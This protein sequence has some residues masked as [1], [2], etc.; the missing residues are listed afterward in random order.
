MKSGYLKKNNLKRKLEK[1]EPEEENVESENP[2][3]TEARKKP[4]ERVPGDLEQVTEGDGESREKQE[5]N[6][7]RKYLNRNNLKEE[8]LETRKPKM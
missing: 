5:E 3:K 1:G 8:K 6:M 2:K 4:E 7:K